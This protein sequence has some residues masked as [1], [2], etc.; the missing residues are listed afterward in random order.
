MASESYK[1]CSC[2]SACDLFEYSKEGEPCWG[3]TIVVDDYEIEGERYWIHSCEGHAD[4][5]WNEP[6]KIEIKNI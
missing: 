4:C 6:Y 2:G 5:F 1:K 3:E